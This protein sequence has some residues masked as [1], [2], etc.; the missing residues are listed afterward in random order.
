[1]HQELTNFQWCFNVI[2]YFISVS[3]YIKIIKKIKFYYTNPV[4]ETEEANVQGPG[5]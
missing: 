1:M 3:H 2:V 5:C 4:F